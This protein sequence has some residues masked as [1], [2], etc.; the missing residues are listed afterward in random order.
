MIHVVV[1]EGKGKTTS[2]VGLSMRAAGHDLN[3]LF[4]QFLKDDSSGEIS[5]LRENKHITVAHAPVNYG[6]T[7]QMTEEQKKETSLEY[8]KL[9][10]LAIAS[11]AFLIVL[12][13]VIHALNAGLVDKTKLER[14]LN[15]DCEVVLTGYNPPDWLIDKA[16]Y[17]SK[18]E[19]IKHPFDKGA[20]AR[21]G[22]E[23]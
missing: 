15:K 5:S 1:G 20:P 14:V 6:F 18:I 22:V 21:L 3:V 8:D 11:D 12:D 10:D 7:F 17:Y 9:L 16:D 19:K 13:E 2:A 4:I 23:Y